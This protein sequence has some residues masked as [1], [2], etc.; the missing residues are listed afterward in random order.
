MSTA[1]STKSSTKEWFQPFYVA[2]PFSTIVTGLAMSNNFPFPVALL[3]GAAWGIALGLVATWIKRKATLSAW[4]EDAFVMLGATAIAFSAGGGIL[5]LLVLESALGSP[6]LTGETLVQMFLPMI[7][8]YI[9]VNSSMELL[10]IPGLLYLGWRA[11]KRRILIVVVAALFF[12]LRV[13][14]YLAF[15]PN[16]LAFAELAGKGTPFTPAERQQAFIDLQLDDPRAILGLPILAVILLATQFSRVR[17]LK[18]VA[19]S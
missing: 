12:A 4:L 14:S 13:W 9:I 19:A 3:V 8:F 18:S 1:V 17:E 16:R 5:A 15:V 10:I 2:V 6:S 11:G 7:P